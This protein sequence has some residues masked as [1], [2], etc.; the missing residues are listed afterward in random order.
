MGEHADYFIEK[1]ID[2]AINIEFEIMAEERDYWTTANGTKIPY[3]ELTEAHARAILSLAY[4]SGLW[5][6]PLLLERI[7]EFDDIQNSLKKAF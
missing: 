4:K 2:R 7:A 3:L 6:H 5:P 1:M